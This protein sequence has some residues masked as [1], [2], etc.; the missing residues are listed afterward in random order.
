MLS[1]YRA[2][3]TLGSPLIRLYLSRRLANGK[4]SQ[5]RF[6]ERLGNASMPRPEGLVAWIHGASVGESLSTLPLIE[7]LRADHPEWSILVTTGTVTSASL[8]VERLPEGAF[9]QF[10]PVDKFAYVSKF[11]N[12][13]KPD[14]ALW[15]ESEFWPNMISLSATMNIPMVLLNGRVSQKSF[16]V[17][18]LFPG[19]IKEMLGAFSLCLGQSKS[20]AFRLADLGAPNTKSVGNLKF[21][22]PP[23]PANEQAME[24]LSDM[25]GQRPCWLAAS[26]HKGEEEIVGRI[27]KALK[28]KKSKILSIIVPRHPGRGSEI[29]ETLKGMGLNVGLRSTNEEFSSATDIYIADTMGELGLFYR[30]API[31]Y[32]GKSMVSVGGQNPLEA[33]RL[34]C[35]IVFGPHM[36]NFKEITTTF[37]KENACIEVSN[38]ASLLSTIMRLIKTPEECNQLASAARQ[39]ADEQS[40]VLEAVLHELQPFLLRGR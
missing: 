32:I 39:V 21:S 11:F 31:V 36:E 38:E 22:T 5:S 7:R 19:L 10:V 29:L 28:D 20:D 30:L 15:T 23:L 24:K 18:K 2:V 13:W 35:A 40:G 33:A 16:K 1:L 4:E 9:H 17:W 27:H 6:A 3:T 34:D 26:T 37:T 12:H 25:I 8:M 14:L